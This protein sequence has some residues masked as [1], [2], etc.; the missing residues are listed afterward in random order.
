MSFMVCHVWN[1]LIKTYHQSQTFYLVSDHNK[2]F[3]ECEEEPITLI[4]DPTL[5]AAKP[6]P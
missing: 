1:K 5:L 3:L 2:R 6:T 4:P